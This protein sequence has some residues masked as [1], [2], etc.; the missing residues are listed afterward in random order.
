MLVTFNAQNNYYVCTEGNC[1]KQ[2]WRMKENPNMYRT[3]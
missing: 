3:S 2:T 1:L